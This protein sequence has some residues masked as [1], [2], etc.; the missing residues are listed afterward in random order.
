[1]AY[2][3]DRAHRRGVFVFGLL[4]LALVGFIIAMTAEQAGAKYAGVFIAASGSTAPILTYL[5]LGIYPGFPNVVSWLAN[6][7]AGDYKRATGMA[8]QMFVYSFSQESLL[9]VI[10]ELVISVVRSP[11]IFGEIRQNIISGTASRSCLYALDFSQL[12]LCG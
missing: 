5:C 1:M 8:M 12:R 9:T 3:S 6:N 7:L 4:S 10:A 11:A 2:L